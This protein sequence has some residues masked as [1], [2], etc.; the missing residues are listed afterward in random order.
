LVLAELAAR[1]HNERMVKPHTKFE[2][3]QLKAESGWYVRVTLP[4]GAQTHVNYFK[5]A[6]EAQTWID[7]KSSAWL[8]KYMGGRYV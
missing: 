1:P 5:T 6:P 2:P 7:E 4:H 3:V 8:T